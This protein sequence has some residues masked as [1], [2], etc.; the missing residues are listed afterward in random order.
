MLPKDTD[1]P[2][3]NG[4]AVWGTLGTSG[5]PSKVPAPRRDHL[6]VA[7]EIQAL[8]WVGSTLLWTERPWVSLP[9]ELY[10]FETGL[11]KFPFS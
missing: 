11:G 5:L 3:D 2:V 4:A 9:L 6:V 8:A 10:S 7:A 1:Q